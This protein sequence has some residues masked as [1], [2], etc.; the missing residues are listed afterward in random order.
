MQQNGRGRFD[1]NLSSGNA[2]GIMRNRVRSL[3]SLM[4]TRA[5]L[6]TTAILWT[7]FL[8]VISFHRLGPHVPLDVTAHRLVHF[9]AF[10]VLAIMLLT[11]SRNAAETGLAAL[12]ILCVALTT[13]TIEYFLYRQR[14]EWWDIRDD[15][16]GF[17]LALL[18]IRLVPIR[19]VFRLE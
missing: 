10:G 19:S 14:F 12:C 15:A 11:L 18:L 2:L 17:I 1:G 5:A 6:R 13:E 9:A 16:A 7:V 3:P 4:L 8:L